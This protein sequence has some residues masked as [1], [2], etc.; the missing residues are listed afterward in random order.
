MKWLVLSIFYTKAE[1][2]LMKISI[3]NEHLLFIQMKCVFLFSL[4]HLLMQTVF[5]QSK[6]W[7]VM[8]T[9]FKEIVFVCLTYI[10]L[11]DLL[12]I[13]TFIHTRK[14]GEDVFGQFQHVDKFVLS[15]MTSFQ[16]PRKEM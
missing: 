4:G 16:D 6:N 3:K 9:D 8:L 2:S 12:W 13:F 7:I 11:L 5:M 10:F 15:S 1:P 14:E